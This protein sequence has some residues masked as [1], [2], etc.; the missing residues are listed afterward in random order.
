MNPVEPSSFG[1]KCLS[2]IILCGDSML[3][4]GFHYCSGLN[5]S[6]YLWGGPHPHLLLPDKESDVEQEHPGA[7]CA[8]GRSV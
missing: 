7:D 3:K 4:R 8:G 2:G 6:D 5:T 1:L